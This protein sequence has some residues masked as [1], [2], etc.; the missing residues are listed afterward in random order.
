MKDH[1]PAEPSW[2]IAALAIVAI[3]SVSEVFPRTLG[4]TVRPGT[5][6]ALVE[7]DA[8]VVDH[9]ERP[10]PG[11][12][13]EDFQVKEDG[14]AVAVTSFTEVSAGGIAGRADGRSVVLLLDDAGVGP[15]ATTLVRSIARLFLSHVRLADTISVVRLTHHDDEVVAPMAI[16]LQRVEEYRAR[17]EPYFGRET[18]EESLQALTRISKQL[19]PI[20]HRRK[21]VVCVGRRSLC[22]LYIEVPE[23]SLVWP[24]WRDAVTAMAHANVSLYVV[25]PA[26]LSGRF[27]LGNGLVEATG[28]DDFVRSNDFTRDAELVWSQ[29]GHYYLLGYAPGPPSRKLHTIDVKVRRSGVRVLARQQRG[30]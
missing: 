24:F 18:I 27:D 10:V 15:M 14:R 21:T 20:A 3:M 16:A 23:D 22:D 8:V 6:P 13:Q 11:L 17:S 9:D 30:D 25:D 4:Q 29:A 7:L 2:L 26:G 28:G 12:H 1:L 19:E 5:L